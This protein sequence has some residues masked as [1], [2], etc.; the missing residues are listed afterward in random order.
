MILDKFG[1]WIQNLWKD[2]YVAY[3]PL[4]ANDLNEEGLRRTPFGRLMGRWSEI[5]DKNADF[6]F[7]ANA[8]DT[9]ALKAMARGLTDPSPVQTAMQAAMQAANQAL[10]GSTVSITQEEERNEDAHGNF[11]ELRRTVMAGEGAPSVT[12][13]EQTVNLQAPGD[14]PGEAP[15]WVNGLMTCMQAIQTSMVEMIPTSMDSHQTAMQTTMQTTINNQLVT[16]R[17]KVSDDLSKQI[18][19]VARRIG[20]MDLE[21]KDLQGKVQEAKRQRTELTGDVKKRSADCAPT[22]KKQRVD[23][24]K[25]SELPDKE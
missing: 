21:N 18:T 16:V 10:G 9:A 24:Q 12:L 2:E 7:A 25:L 6:T 14:A 11:E 22:V 15:A 20:D 3:I 23:T 13:N 5:G 19:R 17:S 8:G 1:A 4:A